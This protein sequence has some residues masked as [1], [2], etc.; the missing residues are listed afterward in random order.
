M[1]IV[2]IWG[3]TFRHL[4]SFTETLERSH[5]FAALASV[6]PLWRILKSIQLRYVPT[7]A[8]D[9]QQLLERTLDR[10][11]VVDVAPS[12]FTE[13]EAS[14]LMVSFGSTCA[15]EELDQEEEATADPV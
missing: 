4:L 2:K 15:L 7:L 5:H 12:T 10:L 3:L 9:D 6:K 14:A 11:N 1:D 8:D 13:K